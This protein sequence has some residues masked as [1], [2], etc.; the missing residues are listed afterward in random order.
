METVLSL[1]TRSV[2]VSFSLSC[3][4]S[5][6]LCLSVCVSLSLSLCLSLCVCVCD[7]LLVHSHYSPPLYQLS[8][9][10]SQNQDGKA[11]KQICYSF[12]IVLLVKNDGYSY[13]CKCL[14]SVLTKY[15]QWSSTRVCFETYFVSYF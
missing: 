8:Y 15:Y 5:L 10:R 14:H 13:S 3:C 7:D 4:V 12:A 6:S 2:C 11:L 1:F 9:R